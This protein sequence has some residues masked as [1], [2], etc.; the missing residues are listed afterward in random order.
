MAEYRNC[1]WNTFCKKEG[2]DYNGNIHT[3]LT[4]MYEDD[5]HKNAF[6][7][8]HGLVMVHDA[9]LKYNG[10]NLFYDQDS[11]NY[12]KELPIFKAHWIQ[13]AKAKKTKSLEFTVSNLSG[14]KLFKIPLTAFKKTDEFGGQGSG[15]RVNKGNEFEEHWQKD[16]ITFM[17][18]QLTGPRY[19]SKI[20]ELNEK[21]E[22]ETGESLIESIQEGGA[23]KPRPLMEHGKDIVVSAGGILKEDMGETL[24]DITYKYGKEKKPRYLSLKFGPTVT[25]FNCGVTG[26]KKGSLKLFVQSEIEAYN[27]QASAGKRFLEIFGID[28]VRFCQSFADY[29]R[30]SPIPN[31]VESPDYDK[32]SIE[33]LLKSGIGFGYTMVHNATGQRSSAYGVDIYDVDRTYLNS[34]STITTPVKIFYG[35]KDGRGKRVDMT[36]SSSKYDFSFNIRNKQGG[37]FPSHVMCD[38]VKR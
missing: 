11:I 6:E 23:N 32:G 3:F 19:I 38:Y 7:T 5:N 1:A 15:P 16:T 27:I 18:G 33:K 17:S 14:M 21:F 10:L 35:G 13:A 37:V 30:S 8:D 24:T 31:H 28:P 26:A 34:A 4:K 22:K 2:E 25:F 20:K 36:C 9:R 12:K 29:P